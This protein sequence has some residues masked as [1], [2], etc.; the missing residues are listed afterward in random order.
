MNERTGGR[1]KEDF[2][3]EVVDLII[4]I[5]RRQSFPFQKRENIFLMAKQRH[6]MNGGNEA[7]PR[8]VFRCWC[9]SSSL[10]YLLG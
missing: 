3:K 8:G 6:L 10:K 2:E 5:L 4:L 9:L 1:R 7:F